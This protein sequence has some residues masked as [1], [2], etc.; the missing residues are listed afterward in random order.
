[1]KDHRD[2]QT[3]NLLATPNAIR[4]ARFADAQRKLGRKARKIWAT[5]DEAEALRLYL[6][7]LRAA[8]GGGSD[9]ASA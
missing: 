1:M 6:E 5:D 9:P 2:T 7:E 3:G 4:Q 8:Q